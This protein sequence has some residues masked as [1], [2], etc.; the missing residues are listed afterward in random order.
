LGIAVIDAGHRNSVYIA[1][2]NAKVEIEVFDP[3]AVQARRV[4]VSGAI[5]PVV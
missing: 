4:V 3:S 2:P 1:Y 5:V